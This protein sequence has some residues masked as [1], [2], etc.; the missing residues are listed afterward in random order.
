MFYFQKGD[1]GHDIQFFALTPSDDKCKKLPKTV[2]EI[3][4]LKVYDL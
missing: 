3:L 2:S 1:Q 4:K